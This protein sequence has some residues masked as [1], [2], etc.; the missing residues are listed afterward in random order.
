MKRYGNLW[1]R[2]IGWDNLV[3]AAHKAHKGKRGKGCVQR[4]EFHLEAELLK[5]QNELT[6]GYYV[7]GD[8]TTHWITK[9]KPRKISAAPY[10]DRVVHHALMNVL[11]PIL[12]RHF[13]PDSYACRKEKGTHAA[14]NRLQK[15]MKHNRYALQ[16]DIRKFF[17][18]IDHEILKGMFRQ[19]IRDKEALHLMDMVVDYSNEQELVNNYFSSDDLFTPFYRRRGLPI[20][21]LTSQWFANWYLNGLDHFITKQC[22]CGSYVR[23]CDDFV[24]LAK[25]RKILIDLRYKIKDYLDG[26]RLRLHTN[27]NFIRPVKAGLTFVGMRIW[28]YH[29]LLRKDNI[30]S[31]KKRIKWMQK[32]YACGLIDSD[33]IQPRLASWIGHSSNTNN[34]KLLCRLC[35]DWR[36]KRAAPEVLPRYPRRQL[37][38]QRQQLRGLE[39]EQQQPEQHEQQQ[40]VPGVSLSSVS[41]AF[42]RISR[43]CNV[44]GYYNSGVEN[45]RCY[46]ELMGQKPRGQIS[47]RADI[48][49][50]LLAEISVRSLINKGGLAA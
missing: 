6:N 45:P 20:G 17:P 47:M 8:F 7:P 16:C 43:N 35:K 41:P 32:A 38:Q 29:R 42:S 40:R 19:L 5:L 24:I 50:R 25:D 26:I 48:A 33:Y 12:D 46:P 39:P 44:H 23:Y 36:F 14:A 49:G 9:P 3:L 2:V 18:S 37:E 22:S 30:K 15:L 28:P 4:F 27:R 31:F 1:E 11:E 13:H 21:N 34:Y 10:R